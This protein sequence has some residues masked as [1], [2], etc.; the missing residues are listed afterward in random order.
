MPLIPIF[1]PRE[2]LEEVQRFVLALARGSANST[3]SSL[4]TASVY[5]DRHQTTTGRERSADDDADDSVE[6][7]SMFSR[8]TTDTTPSPSPLAPRQ[9]LHNNQ[10]SMPITPIP[11]RST[12][13]P[14]TPTPT[15]SSNARANTYATTPRST[16]RIPTGSATPAA[17]IPIPAA[18]RTLSV[19]PEHLATIANRNSHKHRRYYVIL[20]GKLAGVFWD[21]WYV[22]IQSSSSTILALTSCP[23]GQCLSSH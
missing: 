5:G 12:N 11:A 14:I 3:P 2:H 7:V 9:T 10:A 19:V 20:V 1:V 15:R 6:L 23:Q 18:R 21:E 22:N 13:I 17:P 8:L 4:R 16:A